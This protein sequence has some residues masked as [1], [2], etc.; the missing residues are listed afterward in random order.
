M[1]SFNPLMPLGIYYQINQPTLYME[2]AT[3]KKCGKVKLKGVDN[4][5]CPYLPRPNY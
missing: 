5:S 1:L 4:L 3:P 2:F